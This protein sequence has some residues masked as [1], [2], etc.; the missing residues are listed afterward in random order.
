MIG[1][2]VRDEQHDADDV[3][4]FDKAPRNG[5]HRRKRS[6]RRRF[7]PVT[8]ALIDGCGPA[9]PDLRAADDI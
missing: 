2:H 6:H 5:D 4:G 3:C 1:N 7:D 9:A 8:V